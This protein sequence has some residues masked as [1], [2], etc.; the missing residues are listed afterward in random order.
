MGLET[1]GKQAVIDLWCGIR[2]DFVTRRLRCADHPPAELAEWLG[3]AGASS[4]AFWFRQ[5]FGCTVSQW[6][7]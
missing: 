7:G 4:F 1:D 3:L 5:Q 6:R 2:R